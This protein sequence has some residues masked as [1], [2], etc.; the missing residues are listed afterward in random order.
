MENTLRSKVAQAL[1]LDA[2]GER[3]FVVKPNFV[4]LVRQ[5]GADADVWL[6]I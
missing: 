5:F 3:R 4:D 6:S 1:S 2:K